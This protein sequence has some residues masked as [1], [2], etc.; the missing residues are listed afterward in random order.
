MKRNLY[1]R[2]FQYGWK[3]FIFLLFFHSSSAQSKV[4]HGNVVDAQNG[5]PL[6]GASVIVKNHPGGTR[7]GANG[8]YQITVPA[9][10]TALVF[11]FTGYDSKTVNISD[12][13]NTLNVALSLNTSSLQDVVVVGYGTQKKED[14]TSAVADV[15][16]KDFNKGGAR[17]A[18]DL[19]RG[20]VAGLTIT[21]TG[22]SNPNSGVAIQLRGI[23]TINGDNG[24]LIVIDGIPGGN[25]DLLQQSDIA[26]ISV[27]KDASAAA[28]YGTRANGGVIL[29]TTKTGKP[30]PPQYEYSGY[31]RK[32]FI[33]RKPD[34]LSAADYRAEIAKGEIGSSNDFGGSVDWFNELVNHDNVSQYHDL[35]L[36][37][38][39]DKLSYRADLFW[40]D[41]QGIALQN[42]RRQ[43]GGRI[44]L[45][46]LGFQDRLTTN[47]NV[48]LNYNKANLLGGNNWEDALSRNP[49]QP[50]FNSDGTYYTDR[51]STNPVALINQ[52]TN[53]RDQQTSSVSFKSTLS[54][55]KGLQ[56]SIFGSLQ[57]DSYMDNQY[58]ELASEGSIENGD[59]PGGGY[60][61]KGSTLNTDY[62]FEPT[63][64][65][66]S[67]FLND[68]SISAVAGYSYQYSVQEN[69]NASNRGFLN[70]VF[71]TNNLGA[72]NAL[73]AGKAG[74][75]SAKSD[76][77]LIAFF[78]RINYSYK[79]KY[80][81]QFILRH[82]GSSRF[83]V[84]NKWGDFPAVSA[85]WVIS[86]EN[87]MKNISA[88]SFLKLRAGYGVTGNQ[89]FGNG[90]SLVTLGTGGF[91][92]NPDGSWQQTYGP[93]RNPNPNLRWEKKKETNI[94]L[95]FRFRNNRIGGS[96][97]VYSRKVVD[98]LGSYT[99]QQ[100]PFVR[101]SIYTNVG[102]IGNKGIELT[103]NATPVR[104][105]NF[106][107]T[108]DATA[109]HATNKLIS[110]SNDVYKANYGTYGGIG[111]FGALGNAIRTYQGG[112]LGQFYGKTF[113]GF[114]SD[115]KWLFY[116][117]DKSKVHFGDI[118]ENDLG[119]I[120]N[121]I[122]KYYASLTN[123]FSYKNF[124]LSVFLRGK[125][126]YDILNTMAIT[127]GNKVTLPNNVLKST[128][129][130]YNQIN[131]TYQYS[132]Y[133]LEPGSFV[134]L[135]EVTLS[136]TFNLK[137]DYIRNLNVYVTG[138][139][140]ALITKYTGND[141]DFVNDTGLAPG[142][143]SRGPYPST[144]SF[145]LGL[146]I[147][148]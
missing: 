69:F 117:A 124:T 68:H 62:A 47:I 38:G 37:G 14:I 118:T 5:T 30:G 139:N 127:Y 29:V 20:K 119:Y 73:P 44:A 129:T 7:T 15:K 13:S 112:D 58:N 1:Y 132:N 116:A 143:D 65:Y 104:T 8:R 70:D 85:G 35:A 17:N 141:P 41:F 134:K 107:W 144:R 24:P 66:K 123:N 87:F 96:I 25:L 4:I 86:S 83:G 53:N 46:Q 45:H 43:Y 71:T 27:L 125:F 105:K 120:G 67:E 64:E 93:D 146:K 106:Q 34:F 52:N 19:I 81:A 22:S 84:N 75:G 56:A 21:R 74:M 48:A 126:G 94:G 42:E 72:G 131:D 2:F 55:Y 109:S 111:G 31:V 40:E 136:Y 88:I 10:A 60:A 115:G 26:S 59:F 103:L 114:D 28:I 49:T 102:S 11:S 80:L 100:P 99:A 76:N 89:G 130:K 51:L 135:D 57:R 36:S 95:D 101:S 63:I 79:S 121:G 137:T 16:A 78:G 91:Y 113:A 147:G 39:T 54:L 61:Y 142:I 82:E 92:I 140:L 148:F 90:L 50:I 98:L 133:Y 3:V 6:N 110:Y 122:P 128:F 33:A 18:M 32:E 23:N 108:I 12:S 138:N 9:T 77:T 97:D 145:L